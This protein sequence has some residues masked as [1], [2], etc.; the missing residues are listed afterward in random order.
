MVKILKKKIILKH[1][2]AVLLIFILMFIIIGIIVFSTMLTKSE[3]TKE[4]KVEYVAQL[5]N[6][7]QNQK[8]EIESEKEM[9]KVTIKE[10]EPEPEPVETGPKPL[11]TMYN[12]FEVA[13]KI[14]IPKTGVDIPF[15]SGVTVEGME[16]APCLLYK[17]GEIN[18][19]GNTFI[20]GHNYRNG[21]LFSNNNNIEVGDK[22]I[23]TAMDG[24]SK[25][26][27]VYDKF[28]TTAEDVSYLKREIGELPEITLQSCTDD[29]EN[30]LIILAR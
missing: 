26:Y 19:S 9:L 28:T 3:K 22:I 15:L 4:T 25:E 12:G 21:T 16:Q 7:M 2:E 13:G 6:M 29:D 5:E 24:T 8:E 20:V 17:T 11:D 30:R 1:T 18:V 14:T 27:T 10:K 23:I